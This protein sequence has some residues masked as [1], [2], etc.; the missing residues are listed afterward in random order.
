VLKGSISGPWTLADVEIK[1][2]TVTS[3]GIEIVGNRLGTLYNKENPGYIKGGKLRIHVAKLVSDVDSDAT[4]NAIFSRIFIEL[5]EDLRPMLP[6]CWA[7]YLEGTDSQSRLAAWKASLEK[8]KV[9]TIRPADAPPG[10]IAP[11]HLVDSPDPKYTKEARLHLIEGLSVLRTVIDVTGTPGNIAIVQPLGMG[12]DEQAVLALEQW[13]FQ[14]ATL[15]GEPVPDQIE[16]QMNFKCC[17]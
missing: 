5:G 14:P 15:N 16:V 6:D 1:G 7:Y 4:L 8:R 12:L 13:K 11:P 9:V 3:Q 2:V 17:P 10:K